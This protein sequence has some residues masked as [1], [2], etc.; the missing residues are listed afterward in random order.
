MTLDEKL[1]DVIADH[2]EGVLAT[3]KADGRPQLSN[4]LYVWDAPER[5]ARISTTA[6]RVKAR[7]LRRDQRASLYVAGPHFWSYAVADGDTELIGPTTVAGDE[8]G[9]ELLLVHSAFYGGL[10][11][12]A[13]FHQMVENQ[14]LVIRLRVTHVYGVVLDRPPGG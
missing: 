7:D 2:R 3:I 9:R 10:D 5:T 14:R 6:T 11:E 12:D 4:I 13:F 1:L 8:A